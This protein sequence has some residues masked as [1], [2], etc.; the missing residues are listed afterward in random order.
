MKWFQILHIPRGKII[1]LCYS[2]QVRDLQFYV[3]L[4]LLVHV[5]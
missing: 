2:K 1:A 3:A 4:T 5:V